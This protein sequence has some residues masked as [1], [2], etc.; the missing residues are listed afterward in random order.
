MFVMF[1]RHFSVR[2]NKNG[3]FRIRETFAAKPLD[4]WGFRNVR[5]LPTYLPTYLPYLQAA[6]NKKGSVLFFGYLIFLALYHSHTV[7][8]QIQNLESHLPLGLRCSALIELQ[9]RV[10]TVSGLGLGWWFIHSDIAPR[11]IGGE[12]R[13]LR[14]RK[15][16]PH[17]QIPS[18]QCK[19]VLS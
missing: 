7:P 6:C 3:L 12:L 15:H 13:V 17:F 19:I 1:I 5:N 18:K 4:V 16:P 8:H 11:D 2:I 10:G 14:V 9:C